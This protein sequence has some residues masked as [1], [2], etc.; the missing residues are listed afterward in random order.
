VLDR[1]RIRWGRVTAVDGERAA[2]TF[3]PLTWDGQVLSLGKPARETARLSASAAIGPGDWV[4]LHWEW[5]CDRLTPRQL[6][7]LRTYT[8]FHLDLLN[9]KT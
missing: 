5:V 9:R 6:T 7:A 1:C 8:M 4:S 2:V 3:R